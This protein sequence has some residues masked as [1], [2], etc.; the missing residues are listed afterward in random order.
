MK[1][2]K[3]SSAKKPLEVGKYLVVDPRICFG[4]M[5]FKAQTR[6]NQLTFEISDDGRGI[7]WDIIAQQGMAM[8]LPSRVAVQVEAI[9]DR[10]LHI[11]E[12]QRVHGRDRRRR[13]LS[14]HVQLQRPARIDHGRAQPVRAD[15]RLL[16]H[17]LRTLPDPLHREA[18]EEEAL[19]RPAVWTWK[20]DKSKK[21]EF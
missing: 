3:S 4:K 5:T 9:R 2:P 1:K 20:F 17:P 7:D 6:G 8:G 14:G 21:K 15:A 12:R 10:A 16:R 18:A 11:R 13:D 19:S